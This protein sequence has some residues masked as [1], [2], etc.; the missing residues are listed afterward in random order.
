ML[1]FIFTSSRE[2]LRTASAKWHPASEDDGP[3]SR[4]PVCALTRRISG[5][6]SL[7]LRPARARYGVPD[8]AYHG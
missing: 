6:L 7:V 4:P 2:L 8:P 5:R 3:D 1:L